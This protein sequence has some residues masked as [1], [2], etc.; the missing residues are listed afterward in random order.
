MDERQMCSQSARTEDNKTKIAPTAE[1]MV[2]VAFL[3]SMMQRRGGECE[4]F[5]CYRPAKYRK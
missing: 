3:K 2:A 4:V 1:N 5:D